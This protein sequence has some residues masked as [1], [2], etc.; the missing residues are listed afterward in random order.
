[1]FFM[2]HHDAFTFDFSCFLFNFTLQE[3][4]FSYLAPY[5]WLEIHPFDGT[6]FKNSN[7]DFLAYKKKIPVYSLPSL[8]IFKF[9]VFFLTARGYSWTPKNHRPQKL[10][11]SLK[12]LEVPASSAGPS[13][14]SPPPSPLVFF[15]SL[16]V[17][18]VFPFRNGRLINK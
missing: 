3:N 2:L 10:R 8:M 17:F 9:F 15:L 11:D 1:M 13:T 4:P 12:D 18:K 5:S 16:G 6:H 14:T 7:E